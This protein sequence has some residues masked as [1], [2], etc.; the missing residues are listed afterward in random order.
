MLD[1]PGMKRVSV[2]SNSGMDRVSF[3]FFTKKM[4]E[5]EKLFLMGMAVHCADISNP[6]KNWL[7]QAKWGLMVNEEFFA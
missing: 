6:T 3:I 7:I 4:E 1:D 5:N 2:G